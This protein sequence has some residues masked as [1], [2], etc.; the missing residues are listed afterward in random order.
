MCV[1]VNER[2]LPT[3]DAP[4]AGV[5]KEKANLDEIVKGHVI[6]RCEKSDQRERPTIHTDAQIESTQN[7]D[8]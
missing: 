2:D 7:R 3:S 5:I 1:C 6:A 8:G 4:A